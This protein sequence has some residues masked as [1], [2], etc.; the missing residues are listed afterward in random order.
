MRK[1]RTFRYAEQVREIRQLNK[2]YEN[3]ILKTPG[4]ALVIRVK[5]ASGESTA[6]PSTRGWPLVG[7]APALLTRGIF[8][9]VEAAWRELGDC[10][11]LRA[12]PAVLKVIVHPDDVEAMLL[13]R[14]DRYIKGRSYTQFRQVVGEG[15]VTSRGELWRRQRRLIQ[16]SFSRD[17]LAELA[18]LIVEL[19]AATLDEWP[20]RVPEGEAFDIFPELLRLTLEII[21]RGLFAVEF[22]DH[23]ARIS[24]E[25]FGD[26]LE[27]V[28]KRVGE[29]AVPPAWLP[30]PGNRRLARSIRALEAVVDEIVAKRRRSGELGD[31]LLGVLL[32]AEDEQGESMRPEQLRDEVLTMFLAGHETT[33]VALTWTLWLLAQNPEAKARLIDELDRVLAGR[34]PTLADLADLPWTKQVFQESMR[35]FPPAWSGARDCVAADTLGPGLPVEP[36]DRVLNII[37]LTHRHPEFWSEPERFDPERFDPDEVAARHNFAYTPFSAGPRRCVGLHLANM[38]A[39]LVLA[40]LLSRYEIDVVEGFVAEPDFLLTTRPKAGLQVRWRRRRG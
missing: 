16:P 3:V 2:D 29:I 8:P 25:A 23:R 4:R 30:T 27:I 10:F 24:T 40:S 15:L 36:G 26:S 31:D 37:W 34:P 38:E 20:T 33:A 1:K 21:G 6:W 17:A 11:E 14:R 39:Q 35:L 5:S 18:E 12:G 9:V 13:T 7:H 22:G 28:G 19:S 32:R